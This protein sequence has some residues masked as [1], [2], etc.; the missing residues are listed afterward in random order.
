M[1][2]VTS[3]RGS[4]VAQSDISTEIWALLI[5]WKQPVSED[6]GESLAAQM[7]RSGTPED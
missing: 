7:K 4:C 1:Q 6:Q 5:T 2:R 3:R